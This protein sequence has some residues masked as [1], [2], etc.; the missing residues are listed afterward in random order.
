MII[1]DFNTKIVESG[2][3]VPLYAGRKPEY[4][5]TD[6]SDQPHDAVV[7]LITA[8]KDNVADIYVGNRAVSNTP[9]AES[10]KRLKPGDEC[11]LPLV[12]LREVYVVGQANDYVFGKAFVR[13]PGEDLATV[14]P[15]AAQIL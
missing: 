11:S 6:G 13:G 7:V 3:P 2:V 14:A 1:Y 4:D 12:S 8:H 5:P 9:G 10:G 15:L